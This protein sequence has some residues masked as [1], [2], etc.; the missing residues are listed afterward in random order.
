MKFH[1]CKA[2]L[3]KIIVADNKA[4][5]YLLTKDSDEYKEFVAVEEEFENTTD[6]LA[7]FYACDHLIK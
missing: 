4:Y 7:I 5:Y 3:F 2:Q 1:H 6:T